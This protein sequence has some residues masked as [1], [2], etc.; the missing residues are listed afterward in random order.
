MRATTD[1]EIGVHMGNNSSATYGQE[2]NEMMAT[3]SRT[4]LALQCFRQRRVG[5]WRE[6]GVGKERQ[7][8]EASREIRVNGN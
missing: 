7:K 5:G 1:L 6:R 4:A 3:R 2:E 8:G